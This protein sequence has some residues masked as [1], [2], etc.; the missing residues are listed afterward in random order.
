MTL[1][2]LALPPDSCRKSGEK[3]TTRNGQSW[4]EMQEVESMR[5]MKAERRWSTKLH[6][7]EKRQ[8][9]TNQWPGSNGSELIKIG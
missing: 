8:A 2:S 3:W 9:L 4:L 6:R 1:A 5:R 7:D